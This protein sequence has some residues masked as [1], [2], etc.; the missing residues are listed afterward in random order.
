M[1]CSEDQFIYRQLAEQ[2]AKIVAAGGRVGLGAH[3]QFNGPGAHW[4]LWMLQSG[5]MSRHDALRVATRYGAESIGLGKDVGS[6]E[7]GKLADL[8]VLDKN[9]LDDIRNSTSIK[10]VMKNGRIYEGSTLDEVWPRQIK[11]PALFSDQ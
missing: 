10:W 7:A 3:G 2:A 8:L 4:E 5:G 9:P 11:R 1:Y 6:L